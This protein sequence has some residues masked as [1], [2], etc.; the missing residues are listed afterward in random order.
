V[1]IEIER[2]FLVS[3]EGW[4]SL[5][6]AVCYRQGYLLSDKNRT[7]RIRIAGDRGYITVKG[8]ASGIARSEYEYEIPPQEAAEMLDNLCDRPLIEK[9]RTQISYRDLIWE[10]D[11]FL[12]ENQGLVIAEVE[13][14]DADQ[15]IELPEWIGQEVSNDSR[16]YNSNLVRHPFTRW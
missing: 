3:G 2:K 4:R 11:E 9:T 12:G 16:Y 8:G 6:T 15:A 13:L 1:P 5:G 10:V 14:Q 7:V